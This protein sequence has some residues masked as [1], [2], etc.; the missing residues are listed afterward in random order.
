MSIVS[1]IRNILLAP[2]TE[3]PVIDAEQDTPHTLLTR[4]V[5]PLVL[6][7]TAATFIGYGLIRIDAIFFKLK[8]IKWGAWFAIRQLLSGIIG[9]YTAVYVIDALAPSFSS[10]KNLGKS[11]Q[12]VAYASTPSWVSAI[13]LV[14]PSLGIMGLF[15]LYGIYLFYVGLPVLKKTPEDKRIAY[16]VVAAVVIILIIWLSQWI[17]GS[18]LNP[19][20]GD[21]YAGSMKDLE[22]LFNQ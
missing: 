7:G 1:R 16:M 9:Y 20:L 14:I 19:I 15:G 3:W 2:R 22:N 12:L 17:I 6:L 18:A 4:F 10:E 21:P 13:F 5:L 8:G 11:A